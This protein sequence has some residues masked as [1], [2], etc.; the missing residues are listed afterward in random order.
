MPAEIKRNDMPFFGQNRQNR[1]E[2]LPTVA[3]SVQQQEQRSVCRAF[4]NI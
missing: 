3:K 2:D 1:L 4:G